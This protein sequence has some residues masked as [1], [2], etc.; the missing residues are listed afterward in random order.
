MSHFVVAKETETSFWFE[1]CDEPAGKCRTH[2]MWPTGPHRRYLF[3]KPTSLKQDEM[4]GQ[5]KGW[6]QARFPKTLN[7]KIDFQGKEL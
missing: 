1:L 7:R 5:I 4:L 3:E 2:E 6:E